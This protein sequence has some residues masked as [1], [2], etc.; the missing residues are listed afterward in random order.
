[1]VAMAEGPVQ[2]HEEVGMDNLRGR[3]PCKE[4]KRK[5]RIKVV[6]KLAQ[7]WAELSWK[8]QTTKAKD[9]ENVPADVQV[10]DLEPEEQK[11]DVMKKF[12]DLPHKEK[13]I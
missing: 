12:N 5:K 9:E 11:M 7:W 4:R 8:L 3:A 6:G 13:V 2:G 1:M 10:R